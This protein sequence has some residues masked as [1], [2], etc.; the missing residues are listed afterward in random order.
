MLRLDPKF[1]EIAAKLG[2][3]WGRD[4]HATYGLADA[5]AA[6]LPR[7]LFSDAKDNLLFEAVLNADGTYTVTLGS[8]GKRR[9]VLN[10]TDMFRRFQETLASGK[11]SGRFRAERN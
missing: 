1:C 10:E 4:V 5:G 7:A 11:A 6:A 2:L 8:Q 9:A 3:Q